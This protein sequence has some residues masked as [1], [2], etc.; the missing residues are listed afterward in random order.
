MT[1][2]GASRLEAGPIGAL[3]GLLHGLLEIAG[4]D[5]HADPVGVGQLI[6]AD[7]I[8]AADLVAAEAEGKR[9][10]VEQPLH[11]VRDL[12]PAGAAIGADRHGVG[13]GNAH[14]QLQGRDVVDRAGDARPGGGR[15]PRAVVAEIGADIGDVLDAHAEDP[16][17]GIERHLA[18]GD[19]VAAVHVGEECLLPVGTPFDRPAEALRGPRDQHRF[20][21][22]LAAQAEAAADIGR[23]DAHLLFRHLE[24]DIGHA[25]LHPDDALRRRVERVFFLLRVP[26]ADRDARLHRAADD[27]VVDEIERDDLVRLGEGGLDILAVMALPM[28]AQVRAMLRPYEGRAGVVRAGEIDDRGQAIIFDF[29]QFGGVARLFEALGD[30]IGDRV[31]DIAH[32]AARQH[33]AGRREHLAAVPARH[34]DLGRD[35]GD[36]VGV[37]IL[38]REDAEHAGRPFCGRGV[39]RHDMGVGVR[40]A[41]HMAIGLAWQV[42]VVGELTGAGQET[43]VLA[44]PHRLADAELLDDL[45]GDAVAAVHRGSA[46]FGDGS[47]PPIMARP[48]REARGKGR[49]LVRL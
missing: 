24:G 7:E 34:L 39:D 23:D 46:S 1:R 30:D 47:L 13:E 20:R 25:V 36:A 6:R 19:M 16:A 11:L 15:H 48:M 28:D 35:L 38:D 10:L 37:E 31:A 45:R 5:H 21:I 27:A 40:R 26:F 41:Q 4:I 42:D 8:A 44:P 22:E 3:Q 2:Y 43:L 33:R 49:T 14:R 17:V 12:R 29:D 18:M 9:A 32:H